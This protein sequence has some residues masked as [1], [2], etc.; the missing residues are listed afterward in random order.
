M[1][2]EFQARYLTAAGPI[3][4][5]N[6]IAE[7]AQDVRGELLAAGFVVLGVTEV[8]AVVDWSKPVWDRDEFAAAMSIKAGTLSSKK[9][10]GTIPWNAAIGGVPRTVALAWFEKQLN[11]AGKKLLAA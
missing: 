10:D 5:V 9:G 1:N 4:T 3:E 7:H 8:R 6:I 2:H 11:D